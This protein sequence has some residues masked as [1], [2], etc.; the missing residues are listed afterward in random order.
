M[1]SRFGN[2]FDVVATVAKALRVTARQQIRTCSSKRRTLAEQIEYPELPFSADRR[3]RGFHHRYDL[4]ACI[5]CERCAR[6]CPAGCIH[7]GKERVP[8]RRGFQITSFT[9]DYARCLNCGLCSESCPAE[10]IVMGS[11]EDLSRCSREG[12]IVDFSRLP[13]EVAWGPST[14]D[15]VVAARYKAITRPAQG[16]PYQYGEGNGS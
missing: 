9:I 12:C 3:F 8:G 13:A 10:C 5:A 7:V 6:N 15:P 11:S 16:G 4:T 2:I 1:L 14:L